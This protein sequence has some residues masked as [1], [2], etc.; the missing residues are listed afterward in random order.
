M[1][2]RLRIATTAEALLSDHTGTLD[3]AVSRLDHL[4]ATKQELWDAV[5]YL[6]IQEWNYRRAPEADE[7]GRLAITQI[8][9]LI[10]DL[11]ERQEREKAAT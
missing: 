8:E 5:A 7:A 4:T 2:D 10:A 3:E 1:N 6:A 11:R 9:K